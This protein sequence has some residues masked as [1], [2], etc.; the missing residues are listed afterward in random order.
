M[1]TAE[2]QKQLKVALMLSSCKHRDALQVGW[3]RLATATKGEI[4]E[5]SALSPITI[6]WPISEV[7]ED[8]GEGF[9]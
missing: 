3:L 2:A 9:D 8:E 7:E 1:R 6:R 5:T 4:R